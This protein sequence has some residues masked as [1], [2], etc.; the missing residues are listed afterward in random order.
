MDKC[1]CW[2]FTKSR[3]HGGGWGPSRW[4]LLACHKHRFP[5]AGAFSLQRACHLGWNLSFYPTVRNVLDP[6]VHTQLHSLNLKQGN[7]FGFTLY[8]WTWI[9]SYLSSKGVCGGL[10]RLLVASQ[11]ETKIVSFWSFWF[12]LI[13]IVKCWLVLSKQWSWK[14]W[15]NKMQLIN[16]VPLLHKPLFPLHTILQATPLFNDFMQWSM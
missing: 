8:I 16:A 14:L 12:S 9:Y 1:I 13:Q 11:Q 4:G 2:R 3:P 6:H 7:F 10:Q 5:S 15:G